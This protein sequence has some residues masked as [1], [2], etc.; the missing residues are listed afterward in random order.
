MSGSHPDGILR[1]DC[2][3]GSAKPWSSPLWDLAHTSAVRSLPR[4]HGAV[5]V[6]VWS[7]LPCMSQRVEYRSP[8][9]LTGCTRLSVPLQDH[10]GLASTPHTSHQVAQNALYRL[11]YVPWALLLAAPR[12]GKVL[13]S[14]FARVRHDYPCR[15][16]FVRLVEEAAN[17]SFRCHGAS[18]SRCTLRRPSLTTCL[19]AHPGSGVNETLRAYLFL[20]VQILDC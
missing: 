6:W 8:R 3:A 16:I 20:S 4:F 19:V 14:R 1:P 2:P 10:S 15:S 13:L 7:H 11:C 18:T 5:E 12:P 9:L 17:C